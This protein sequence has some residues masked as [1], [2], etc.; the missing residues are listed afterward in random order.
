VKAEELVK[1]AR[2]FKV[3]IDFFTDPFRLSQKADFSWRKSGAIGVEEITSFQDK[4]KGWIGAYRALAE[5]EGKVPA[6]SLARVIEDDRGTLVIMADANPG[7]SGAA[8]RTID[9]NVMIVNRM[10]SAERRNFDLAHELFHVLTWNELPRPILTA[11]KP[12]ESRTGR[13][14]SPTTSPGRSLRQC[15]CW[16]S[17]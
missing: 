6:Q 5:E 14:G 4:A 10:E 12:I 3:S 17:T 13:R 15:I 1:L 16:K 9:M 8:C 2:G 11:K 7:I